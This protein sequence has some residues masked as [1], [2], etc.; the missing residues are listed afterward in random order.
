MKVLSILRNNLLP[1]KSTV[2]LAEEKKSLNLTDKI[3]TDLHLHILSFLNSREV[4]TTSSISKSSQARAAMLVVGEYF[5]IGTGLQI[6]QFKNPCALEEMIP[7]KSVSSAEIQKSFP[8][9]G[10]VK[11]FTSEQEAQ[12]YARSLRTSSASQLEHNDPIFQP[13]VFK[14]Q[15]LRKPMPVFTKQNLIIAPAI[16]NVKT[17]PTVVSIN[18][19][20]TAINNIAP[21]EGKL[22]V[23][24]KDD[25][26]IKH[27]GSTE[28][29]AHVRCVIL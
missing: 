23:D 12:W 3:S 9:S 1:P 27:Y 15:L 11:L 21:I 20:E 8:N 5:M 25:G 10:K 2:H 29:K 26:A 6:G 28:E 24:L 22:D 14:V 16:G 13:A 4:K 19:F 7:Q 17:F 18:Y